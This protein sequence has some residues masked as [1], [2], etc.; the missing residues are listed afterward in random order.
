MIVTK[1]AGATAGIAAAI[2]VVLG[3]SVV[4]KPELPVLQVYCDAVTVLDEYTTPILSG[5][6]YEGCP[7]R[8][9]PARR[10]AP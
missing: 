8:T 4:P 3:P 9:T 7:V 6:R 5:C 2:G 1:V 10:T